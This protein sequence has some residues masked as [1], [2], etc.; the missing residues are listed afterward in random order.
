MH[1]QVLNN[2]FMF[3]CVRY[4]FDRERS[5]QALEAA[6]RVGKGEVGTTLEHLLSQMFIESF[7]LTALD[8]QVPDSPS[9]K[10]CMALRQEEAIAL[11][12]IYGERFCERIS[13]RVWTIRLDLLWMTEG[14]SKTQEL[15]KK[16]QVKGS[17]STQVCKFY[18]RGAGCKFG[19][20]CHFKH[21]TPTESSHYKDLCG[22][23]QPGFSS[24]DCP[25]HQLEVRF[26]QG[27]CYPFQPPLAAFSTTDEAISRAGRLTVTEYLFGQALSA[28]QNGEPVVYTLISCLEENGPIKELLLASHH[29]YS[30]PPPVLAPSTNTAPRIRSTKCTSAESTLSSTTVSSSRFTNEAQNTN[31]TVLHTEGK[32]LFLSI[33]SGCS[34]A[35]YKSAQT[36]IK[37]PGSSHVPNCNYQLSCLFS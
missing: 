5:R 18:L 22:P 21:Q 27:S 29:K 8:L 25:V 17:S 28:A 34:L 11:T 35:P 9:Y 31:L 2:S 30:A 1:T 10:E 24:A 16:G 37:Y 14:C 6:E 32:I 7:G 26:P 4:G 33:L 19:K 12:A 23:S 36:Q 20:R 3:V 15:T 13:G